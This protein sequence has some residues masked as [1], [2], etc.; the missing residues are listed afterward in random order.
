LAS[1]VISQSRFDL[2][3]ALC[4]TVEAAT[5]NSDNQLQPYLSNLHETTRAATRAAPA[6]EAH[7]LAW[8]SGLKRTPEDAVTAALDAV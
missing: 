6:P 5:S 2:A 4:A 1:V 7:D 3:A 8:Q